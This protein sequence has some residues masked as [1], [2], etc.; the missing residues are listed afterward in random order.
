MTKGEWLDLLWDP[1]G[2]IAQNCN[3]TKGSIGW[4]CSQGAGESKGWKIVTSSTRS[5]T[6]AP[7]TE[8]HLQNRVS[9]LVTDKRLEV[10]FD[11]ASETAEPELLRSTTKKLWVIALGDSPLRGREVL[12]CQSDPSSREVCCLLGPWIQDIVETLSRLFT[13]CT[14]PYRGFRKT[15]PGQQGAVSALYVRLRCECIVWSNGNVEKQP[16][17]PVQAGGWL[18]ESSFD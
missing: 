14:G 16:H 3:C 15:R 9:A 12:A 2:K 5:K 7:P 8:L 13:C 10:V 17:A 1:A 18:A 4:A 11:E 6:P